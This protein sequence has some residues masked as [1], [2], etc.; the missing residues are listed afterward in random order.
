[1]TASQ[2]FTTV[3]QTLKSGGQLQDRTVPPSPESV[4]PVLAAL[5]ERWIPIE[6]DVQWL[7]EGENSIATL[8]RSVA[9]INAFNPLLFDLTQAIARLKTEGDSSIREIALSNNAVLITQRIA[10]N[11]NALLAG[12]TI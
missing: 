3:L 8:D 2:R 1:R 9:M 5:T 12:E 10:K 4:Q 11:A 7:L 6:Q